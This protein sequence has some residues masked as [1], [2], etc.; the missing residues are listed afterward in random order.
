MQGLMTTE[1]VVA[2]LISFLF[3]IT[4]IGLIMRYIQR[5]VDKEALELQ[6]S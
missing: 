6:Q 5:L 2:A 4:L 1:E 3:I